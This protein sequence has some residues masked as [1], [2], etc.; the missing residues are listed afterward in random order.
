M[1]G[2][3]VFVALVA[4]ASARVR[5]LGG[6]R[7]TEVNWGL[8]DEQALLPSW[9]AMHSSRQTRLAFSVQYIKNPNVKRASDNVKQ[10]EK[11]RIS[12][13]AVPTA[14]DW[15]N[16]SGTS[17]VTPN[18]NQHIPQYCGSCWAHGTSSAVSSISVSFVA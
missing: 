14:L 11:T 1:I 9:F 5:G 18:L 13:D 4:G 6:A 10:F 8:T 7:A 12:A 15:R 16:V 3:A 17:F 2:K